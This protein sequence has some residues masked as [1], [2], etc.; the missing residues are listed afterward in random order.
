[1]SLIAEKREMNGAQ[2]IVECLKIE[3]VV[4]VFCVPGESYLPLLE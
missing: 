2:A 1:M 4:K 3:D